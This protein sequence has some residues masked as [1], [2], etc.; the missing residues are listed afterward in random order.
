MV[1]DGL[2]DPY[3]DVHMG[4]CA[5]LCAAEYKLDREGQDAYSLESYR[6][7]REA[8]EKGL[9]AEEIV[10]VQHPRQEGGDGGRPRR[11]A[12]QGRPRQD[13]DAAPRLP[14]GAAGR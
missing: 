5:E 10:P 11:G 13:L 4:N 9:F 7:S 6:R 1:H 14:E 3:G 8:T 12:V 2:W